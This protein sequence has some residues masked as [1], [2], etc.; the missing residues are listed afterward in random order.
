MLFVETE[1][2]GAFVIDV[3]PI[4]DE[5]GFFGRLWCRNEFQERGLNANVAQANVAF[6]PR[7]GTL[8]GLHYQEAPHA[9]TKLVRCTRGAIYDVIVD[10]RG[11]SP[12]RRQWIGVE[13]TAENRRSLYVPEGFAHGYQTL[14]DDAEMT[15][16]TSAFY[17]R[18]SARGVRY[19]DPRLGIEWPLP[20]AVVSEQDLLWP[21][22]EQVSDSR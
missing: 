1:L 7:A 13:L 2:Q 6:S 15:Y 16:Q 11:G 21:L 20:V 3:E 18:E 10:L 22:L 9:E 8:R 14:T 19:D 5:R 12:T 17:K 4:S